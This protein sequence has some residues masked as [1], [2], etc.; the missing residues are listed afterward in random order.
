[1]TPFMN[2]LK[3]LVFLYLNILSS[4]PFDPKLDPHVSILESA[5]GQVVPNNDLSYVTH[6]ADPNDRYVWSISP[7][8]GLICVLPERV[9]CLSYLPFESDT[10]LGL[11]N[12]ADK[13]FPPLNF[14][15]DIIFL[16]NGLRIRSR[17]NWDLRLDAGVN[18]YSDIKLLPRTESPQ[19][20]FS[21]S[22]I[23]SLESYQTLLL[24]SILNISFNRGT[25]L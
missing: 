24:F 1:M 25:R 2:Q 3:F 12:L 15:F 22:K 8:S 16:K 5:W 7:I 13:M 10:H 4:T 19:Q 14:R 20:I 23:A 17:A 6:N 9:M 11:V 18:E 21:E